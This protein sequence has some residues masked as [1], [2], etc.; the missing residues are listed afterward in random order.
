MKNSGTGLVPAKSTGTGP[1]P[2]PAQIPP[3]W[4]ETRIPVGSYFKL[5]LFST[6]LF[7]TSKPRSEKNCGTGLVPVK[8]TSTW[9]G[10]GLNFTGT[11]T[12][13]PVG[14]Q[15]LPQFGY[16]I[17]S[18]HL[19]PPEGGSRPYLVQCCQI[20][21]TCPKVICNICGALR[22]SPE[23]VYKILFRLNKK[24]RVMNLDIRCITIPSAAFSQDF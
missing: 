20:T 23:L 16:Q 15:S 24:D 22:W 6:V 4:T 7:A 8:Y 19:H 12:G 9:T 11:E 21:L 14:S 18:T 2:V 3:D 13:I 5:Y 1:K 10:T 17:A